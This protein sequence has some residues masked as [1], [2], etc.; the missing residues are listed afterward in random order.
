MAK[1]QKERV[2]EY[3]KRFQGIT[4]LEAVRDLGVYRLAARISEIADD[5]YEIVRTQESALNR[6]G[7]KTYFTRY[8]LKEQ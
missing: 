4:A 1:S 2:L 5:G 7:E 8:S 6:F 3:M